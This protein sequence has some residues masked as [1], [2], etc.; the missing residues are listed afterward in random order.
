ADTR[1]V[2]EAVADL[3]VACCEP[4]SVVIDSARAL[5]TGAPL[6]HGDVPS[7]RAAL[8]SQRVGDPDQ[9]FREAV[10]VLRERLVM[11]RSCGSPIEARGVVAEY[12]LRGGILRVWTSTQAPLPVKHGFARMFGLPEFQVEVIAPDVGGGFG[13]KIMLF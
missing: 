8:F 9:A 4:L 10:H 6:V 12:D 13:T 7:N 3:V 2:A 11:E 1:P 5:V